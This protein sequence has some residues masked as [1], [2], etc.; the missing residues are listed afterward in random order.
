[1]IFAGALT[2]ATVLHKHQNKNE[3]QYLQTATLIVIQLQITKFTYKIQKTNIFYD[4]LHFG[5]GRPA[6]T[7]NIF[8]GKMCFGRYFGSYAPCPE[9]STYFR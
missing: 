6:K 1:M 2:N 8:L 5:S 9:H 7:L 4:K 3:L